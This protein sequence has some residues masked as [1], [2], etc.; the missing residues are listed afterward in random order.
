MDR[1][2]LC[3]SKK[4]FKLIENSNVFEN[5]YEQ[6][7][8]KRLLS[9]CLNND[10]AKIM[11][12]NLKTEFGETIMKKTEVNENDL[13]RELQSLATENWTGFELNINH[14]G[15]YRQNRRGRLI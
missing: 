4:L 11:I 12:S 1:K 3:G 7:L 13:T 14:Q 10:I 2:K 6:H 5:Y 9:K 15:Y 8:A